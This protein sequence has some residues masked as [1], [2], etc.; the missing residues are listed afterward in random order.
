MMSIKPNL[1]FVCSALHIAKK[2]NVSTIDWNYPLN[3][4]TFKYDPD[5]SSTFRDSSVLNMYDFLKGPESDAS[6]VD[7]PVGEEGLTYVKT[8]EKPIY[9]Y[10]K[11][12]KYVKYQRFSSAGQLV[13]TD[14]FNDSRQRF[15]R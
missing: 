13:V 15:K 7:H 2:Q 12:G 11:N 10:Y 3:I 14:Y 9:R 5:V 4:V 1:A 6:K 8:P